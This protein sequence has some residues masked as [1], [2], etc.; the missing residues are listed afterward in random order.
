MSDTARLTAT[1]PFWIAR[2]GWRIV[3]KLGG[4]AMEDSAALAA[5]LRDLAWLHLVGQ[6]V[7]LVHGGGKPIDR[8]LTAAGVVPRKVNGRRVTDSATLAVVVRVLADEI[9]P[10]LARRLREL[11][12]PATGLR[13]ANDCVLRGRPIPELG[14][15]GD[16]TGVN[17]STIDRLVLE[18]T[19]PIV[20]PIARDDADGWL[21][22]NADD[23]A[24]AVAAHWR[25]DALIYLTDTPGLLRDVNDPASVLHRLTPPRVADLIADGTIAGGMVPK[26]QGCLAALNHGVGRVQIL[27]G[28]VHHALLHEALVGQCPG[29]EFTQ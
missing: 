25:A 21:N 24:A 19:M 11:G 14:R 26:V 9:N 13:T 8:A 6:R 15:A 3:V 22:I 20:P 5:T 28:R 17:T 12:C 4:S 7:V 23:A 27:D 1:L 10:D 16:V 29:T 2:R 18:G